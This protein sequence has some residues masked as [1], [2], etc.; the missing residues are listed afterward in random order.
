MGHGAWGMEQGAKSKG[1]RTLV[2]SK[3]Q[4]KIIKDLENRNE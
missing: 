2:R 1:Q 3:L 4:N